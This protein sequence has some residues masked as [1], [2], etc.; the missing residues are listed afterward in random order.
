MCVCV[1]GQALYAGGAGD[2]SEI[3]TSARAHPD[4]DVAK[5]SK[6]LVFILKA[7]ELQLPTRS[8]A[9]TWTTSMPR[10][11]SKGPRTGP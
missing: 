6:E 11:S 2:A 8:T 3:A 9:S 4:R 5:V 10:R 1:C 7:P